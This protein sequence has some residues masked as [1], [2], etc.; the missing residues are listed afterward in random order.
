ML[1]NLAYLIGRP[2]GTTTYALNLIPY[3]NALAP[4]YLATPASGLKS[5]TSVPDNMTADEGIAGHIRRLVWTQFALPKYRQEASELIFSPVPEA[6]LPLLGQQHRARSVVMFHDLIPLRFPEFFGSIKLFYRY[7]VPQILSRAEK[8][9]CNSEATARD[10]VEFYGISSQ[11]LAAIPLAYDRQHFQ[12]TQLIPELTEASD[13]N[14]RPYF[15]MLG[16]QAP[17]KNLGRV[18][19]AMRQISDHCVLVIAGPN[20]ARYTPQLKAQADE[21]GVRS[22]IKFLSYIPY[23]QLPALLSHAHALIFPSLWEGFGLPVLEAMAC[24][25]P[26]ISTNVSSLPEVV[27]DAA[28][29]IDPYDVSAIASA[30]NKVAK[31][32]LLRQQLSR[33][34]LARAQQFSWEK[35]GKATVEVLRKYL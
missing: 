35:T 18:I 7:Y 30:M 5:Y 9:I 32:T 4:R 27:G 21:L 14:D 33:A 24:G 34:G 26:V 8:V 6:P 29:L 31:D 19:E 16:R 17:Y 15:L 20:D 22:R 1:V 23:A 28:L 3:L 12:P 13:I 25:T 11:K 10:V 2:T